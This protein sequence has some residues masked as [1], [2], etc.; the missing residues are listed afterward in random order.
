MIA[1]AI[2]SFI[3]QITV[4]K[5][6]G[7]YQLSD[8]LIVALV[9]IEIITGDPSTKRLFIVHQYMFKQEITW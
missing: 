6:S 7:F 8:K 2:M 3:V 9:I 5:H 4:G 1:I